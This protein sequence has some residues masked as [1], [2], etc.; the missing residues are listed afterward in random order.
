M[1]GNRKDTG[2]KWVDPDDAPELPDEWFER[3]ELRDGNKV[4]R[5]GRPK[6]AAATVAISLRLPP[7]VLDQW[8]RT[9]PGWQ[10]RMVASLRQHA[11]KAQR[12]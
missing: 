1:N 7:D 11:P 4:L 8:K 6:S 12:I 9:G 5:R 3:A 10:T 2:S